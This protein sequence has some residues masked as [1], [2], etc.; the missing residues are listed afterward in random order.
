MNDFLKLFEAVVIKHVKG[1]SLFVCIQPHSVK[2]SNILEFNDQVRQEISPHHDPVT[3]SHFP[4]YPERQGESH[5]AKYNRQK[6]LRTERTGHN[7]LV[8]EI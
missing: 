2:R 8:D 4:E 1:N 3:E 5:D 6:S 7:P